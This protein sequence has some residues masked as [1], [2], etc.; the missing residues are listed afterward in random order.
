MLIKIVVLMK[1]FQGEINKMDLMSAEEVDPERGN[2][3]DALRDAA[4]RLKELLK[5]LLGATK[6][7]INTP[8]PETNELFRQQL[9]AVRVETERDTISTTLAGSGLIDAATQVSK[10]LNELFK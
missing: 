10:Q 9:E 4:A 5:G 7:A 8:T 1:P 3:E 2:A 6:A